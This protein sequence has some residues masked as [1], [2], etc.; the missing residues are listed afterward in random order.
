MLND[1]GVRISD[2]PIAGRRKYLKTMLNDRGVRISDTPIAGRRKYLKNMLNDRVVRIYLFGA[3]RL[4]SSIFSD[5]FVPCFSGGP[6]QCA[7]GGPKEP[8]SL[9]KP[10]APN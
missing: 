8:K 5:F 2:T 9:R 1:R 3:P 10:D 7:S 6:K 4:L